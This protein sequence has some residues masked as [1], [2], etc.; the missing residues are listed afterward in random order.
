MADYRPETL[1]EVMERGEP[2]DDEANRYLVILRVP[3]GGRLGLFVCLATT[4]DQINSRLFQEY[5]VGQVEVMQQGGAPIGPGF[6][7]VD[8]MNFG[9]ELEVMVRMERMGEQLL[10]DRERVE[11]MK[12][13]D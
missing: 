10:R 13:E 2:G 1:R 11:A 9:L 5:G 8:L 3:G 4:V 12:R 6:R 7:P